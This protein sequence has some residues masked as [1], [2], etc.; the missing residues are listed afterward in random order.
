MGQVH[1]GPQ[2][3]GG[4]VSPQAQAPREECEKLGLPRRP[5][6]AAERVLTGEGGTRT[7]ILLRLARAPENLRGQDSGPQPPPSRPAVSSL[8]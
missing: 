3:R 5:K 8:N 4:Q 1:D 6:T 2:G 7:A